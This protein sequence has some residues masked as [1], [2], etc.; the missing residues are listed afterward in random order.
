MAGCLY[1]AVS[2]SHPRIL[3]CYMLCYAVY[4]QVDYAVR[5]GLEH[6][7]ERHL[8]QDA[9]SPP[10]RYQPGGDDLLTD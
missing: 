8:H 5:D 10:K 7:I 4:L 9:S 3:P 1:L 2:T 6:K